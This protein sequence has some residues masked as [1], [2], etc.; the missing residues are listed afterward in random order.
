M[1]SASSSRHIPSCQGH[2]QR[3]YCC[4]QRRARYRPVAAISCRAATHP[5]SKAH[6]SA[7][8]AE[9]VRCPSL[10]QKTLCERIHSGRCAVLPAQ[11]S[12]R[13]ALQQI[14]N[15]LSWSPGLAPACRR[16]CQRSSR[17]APH[18]RREQDEKPKNDLRKSNKS[19]GL[20]ERHVILYGMKG[21]QRRDL[22]P[23][24]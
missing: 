2:H 21:C 16:C 19:I 9:R 5:R 18:R 22:Q 14:C 12:Q 3:T 20:S 17:N 24:N 15:S 1:G 8:G 10:T 6:P 7:S 11:H 23:G 4:P 13:S